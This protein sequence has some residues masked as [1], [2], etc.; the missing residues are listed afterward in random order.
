[1]AAGFYRWQHR[2]APSFGAFQHLTPVIRARES[3]SVV[4][5][6]TNLSPVMPGFM[7]GIHDFLCSKASVVRHGRACPGHPRLR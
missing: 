6:A 5:P 3:L 1:M 7:P 4:M 2:F